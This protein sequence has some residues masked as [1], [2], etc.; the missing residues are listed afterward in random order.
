MGCF[1]RNYGYPNLND[2]MKNTADIT[3]G[4]MSAV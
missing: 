3:L 2:T 4:A 1:L